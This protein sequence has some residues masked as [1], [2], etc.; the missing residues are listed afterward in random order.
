MMRVPWDIAP[1][2]L[3][4][5]SPAMTLLQAGAAVGLAIGAVI[6]V[7]VVVRRRNLV[8]RDPEQQTRA[9]AAA[10][11]SAGDQATGARPDPAE[12]DRG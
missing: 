3:E 10:A 7:S 6:A 4:A 2:G 11:P 1:T 5:G 9:D 12:P 8:H